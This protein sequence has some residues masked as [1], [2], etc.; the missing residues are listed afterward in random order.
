LPFD[1]FGV[2]TDTFEANIELLIS[3]LGRLA[4]YKVHLISQVYQYDHTITMDVHLLDREDQV[5][6]PATLN[7]KPIVSRI[8][9]KCSATS[10]GLDFY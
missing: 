6:I 10:D 1:S 7:G 4:E 9:I 8:I 3:P 5:F 2:N